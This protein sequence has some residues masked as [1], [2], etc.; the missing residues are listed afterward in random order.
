MAE[1]AAAQDPVTHL[2]ERQ[3]L[4][5]GEQALIA[6]QARVFRA[7]LFGGPMQG[8]ALAWLRGESITAAQ[9]ENLEVETS[10]TEVSHLVAALLN[11]AALLKIGLNRRP[12]L[13][14]DEAEASGI[15]H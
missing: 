2:R 5:F 11:V 4:K 1:P 9:A 3:V 12:V 13:L 6:S 10:L 14:I 8:A 15:A 7:L